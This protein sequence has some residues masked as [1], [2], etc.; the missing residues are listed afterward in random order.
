MTGMARSYTLKRRAERQDATRR[1]IVEAAIELHQ[2]IG[3]AATTVT[4]IAERAGVGRVT[5]Y[6][7][8]PDEAALAWA[9][10][11][12]YL[13]RNP[14]PD[15]E[16][17]RGIADPGERLRAGLAETFAYHRATEAMMSHV[18]ADARDH[19]VMEPYHA[20][21][22]R[23]AEVLAAPFRARGAR[24]AM[25]RAG[26]AVALGFDT[27]RTLVREHRLSDEQAVDVAVRLAGPTPGSGAARSPGRPGA[28]RSSGGAAPR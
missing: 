20:H 11:G 22:R 5:V 9:C 15:V 26:I 25:L 28:R 8:F 2:T 27:W 6:R 17:W 16:A 10:S 13:R 21:W 24:R 4:D 12:L 1:R 7:H 19:E 14:P 18:L 3:P 23:A